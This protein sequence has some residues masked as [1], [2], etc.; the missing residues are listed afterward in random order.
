V[1]TELSW[2]PGAMV[3]IRLMEEEGF[4]EHV[5]ES[6]NSIRGKECDTAPLSF[7]PTVS[8]CT[9]KPTFILKENIGKLCVQ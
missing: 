7:S 6:L 3:C 2:P 8:L 1:P 9:N 4:C 5:N